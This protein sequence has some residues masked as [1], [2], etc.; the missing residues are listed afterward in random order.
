[1][2]FS[3]C[4]NYLD[5]LTSLPWGKTSEEKFD[6]EHAQK[7]LDEDHHGM[8][9]VKK[10]ILVRSI[11]FFSIKNESFLCLKEFIAV[12]Q[13]KKSTHGKILCFYGPPGV[14]KVRFY[15]SISDSNCFVLDECRQIDRSS[16]ES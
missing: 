13:L 14:G 11:S 15:R 4:T 8:E 5:W 10:R 12:S 1:M 9:D 7:V 3:I 6:L 16:V 2:F